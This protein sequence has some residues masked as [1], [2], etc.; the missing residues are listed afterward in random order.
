MGQVLVPIASHESGPRTGTGFLG[1][2]FTQGDNG[3]EYW[4]AGSQDSLYFIMTQLL[5]LFDSSM[6]LGPVGDMLLSDF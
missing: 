4:N 5:L 6:W 2:R 1:L 3:T